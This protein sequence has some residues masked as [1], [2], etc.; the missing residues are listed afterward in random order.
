MF[1]G[2][3]SP[4]PLFWTEDS[5]YPVFSFEFDWRDPEQLS[6]Y[7]RNLERLRDVS[8]NCPLGSGY[9]L[10]VTIPARPAPAPPNHRTLPQFALEGGSLQLI[11]KTGLQIGPEWWANVWLV[12]VQKP[13][14]LFPWK[15]RVKDPSRP[16]AH[17]PTWTAEVT[18]QWF[19]TITGTIWQL[20]MPNGELAYVLLF[21][22]IEGESVEKWRESYPRHHREGDSLSRPL[23]RDYLLK[24]KTLYISMLRGFNQINEQGVIHYDV[25]SANMIITK[26]WQIVVIGFRRACIH[27]PLQD[28]KEG[29]NAFNAVESLL[30]CCEE[31]R[32][33]LQKW[34]GTELPDRLLRPRHFYFPN[35]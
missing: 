3:I 33:T 8:S 21:E 27:V 2:P 1:I 28:A 14:E 9:S 25:H 24:A 13:G 31:H 30:A 26:D 32:V 4:E 16:C 35:D 15:Y 12:K 11:L 29:S 34:S 10:I 17:I 18:T 20:P 7:C 6:Q 22:Y 23:D 5:R 19:R